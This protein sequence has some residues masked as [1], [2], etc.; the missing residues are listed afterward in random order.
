MSNFLKNLN[1]VKS[2]SNGLKITITKE[3]IEAENCSGMDVIMALCNLAGTVEEHYG[4]PATLAL[5][6]AASI[7]HGDY[8]VEKKGL[9]R[10]EAEKR[11]KDIQNRAVELVSGS[12]KVDEILE[13][14][15]GLK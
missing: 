13:D 8:L 14:L 5:V 2:M 15:G 4:I 1:G 11:V 10:E 6:S 7:I 3:N 9:S 12:L